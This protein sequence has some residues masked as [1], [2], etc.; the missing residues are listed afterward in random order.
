MKMLRRPNTPK[1]KNTKLRIV[2]WL[3]STQNDIWIIEIMAERNFKANVKPPQIF[4]QVAGGKFLLK[5][6][7]K[8]S[9]LTFYST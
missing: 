8:N 7:P 2:T 5:L 6:P 1:Y 9:L 4:D 3:L